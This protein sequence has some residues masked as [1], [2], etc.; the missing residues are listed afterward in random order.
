MDEFLADPQTQQA[1]ATF[2]V[3]TACAALPDSLKDM[4]EQEVPVLIAQTASELAEMLSPPDVCGAV[5]VC[6]ADGANE[7]QLQGPV[8]CPMC[9]MLAAAAMA[10]LQDPEA[11]SRIEHGLRSACGNLQPAESRVSAREQRE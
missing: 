8:D 6:A 11:R 9:R 7:A 2:V 5:G 4:C 1:V 10:R 3:Q